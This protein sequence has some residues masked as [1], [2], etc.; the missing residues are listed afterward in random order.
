MVAGTSG[1]G[2]T[3]LTF[4]RASQ[5]R[6]LPGLCNFPSRKNRLSEYLLGATQHEPI[7]YLPFYLA[8]SWNM[9]VYLLCFKS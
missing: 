2:A 7:I 6:K 3:R 4:S 5:P 9:C 8:S 1:A